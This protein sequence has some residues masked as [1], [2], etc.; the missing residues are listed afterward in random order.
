VHARM[1]RLDA[2]L[3]GGYGA[4]ECESKLE[5]SEHPGALNVSCVSVSIACAR[6]ATTQAASSRRTGSHAEPRVWNLPKLWDRSFPP[7]DEEL[8]LQP[9]SLTPRQQE[10]L[11]H[12]AMWMPIERA[13]QMLERV[14]GVQ[15][16]EPTMRRS[17][18]RAGA[19]YEARQTAQSQQESPAELPNYECRETGDQHRWSLCSFGQG[20]VG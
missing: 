16:S 1:S 12:L 7:L 3:I 9:G 15:V 8:A 5:R 19:L 10:H 17:T 14:L 11:A 18:Q 6:Q 13:A 4:A 2:Q 20:A